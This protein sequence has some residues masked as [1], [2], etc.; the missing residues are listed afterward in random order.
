MMAPAGNAL[1]SVI[2][3]VKVPSPLSTRL[4]LEVKHRS[5][6]PI[7]LRGTESKVVVLGRAGNSVLSFGIG[8]NETRPAGLTLQICIQIL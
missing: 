6:S 8:Q 3:A 7:W 2:V 1:A 4:V 5:E